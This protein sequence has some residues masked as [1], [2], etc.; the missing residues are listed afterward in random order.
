VKAVSELYSPVTGEIVE[1]N[2]ALKDKPEV[3]NANPHESWMVVIKLANPGEAGALL[4]ATQYQDL[5]K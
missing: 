3:V 1:V 2:A 5:V 4:D